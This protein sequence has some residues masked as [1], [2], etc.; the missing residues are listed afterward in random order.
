MRLAPAVRRSGNIFSGLA[1]A[2]VTA[3]EKCRR[4]AILGNVM[5]ELNRANTEKRPDLDLHGAAAGLTEHNLP[6]DSPPA[7]PK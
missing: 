5:T 4:L 7:A 2:A 1:G 3:D 6:D